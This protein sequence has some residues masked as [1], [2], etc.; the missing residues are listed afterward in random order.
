M[1]GLSQ[2]S[3]LHW[4]VWEQTAFASN[5]EEVELVEL[6]KIDQKVELALF[7]CFQMK[8]QFDPMKSPFAVGHR[9]WRSSKTLERKKFEA[10]QAA[11]IRM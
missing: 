8:I 11:Q 4:Q 2:L 9:S 1:P 10:A 5:F 6:V 3:R 7:E